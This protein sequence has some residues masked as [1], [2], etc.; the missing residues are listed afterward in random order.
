MADEQEVEGP[1]PAEVGHNDGV[2][3]H[4]R[5]ELSPWS[6]KFLQP[7]ATQHQRQQLTSVGMMLTG[8]SN[9]RKQS[10]WT[11]GHQFT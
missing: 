9:G 11:E 8:K 10:I 4:G 2:D 5:E 7:K 1:A 3:R 6:F